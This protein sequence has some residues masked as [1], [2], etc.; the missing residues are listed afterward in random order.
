MSLP[1]R[2]HHEREQQ[3]AVK[4]LKQR[5]DFVARGISKSTENPAAKKQVSVAPDASDAAENARS[6]KGKVRPMSSK[7]RNKAGGKDGAE[8]HQAADDFGAVA[9]EEDMI[10]EDEAARLARKET[11][12]RQQTKD[13][14][15]DLPVDDDDDDEGDDD[16]EVEDDFEEEEAADD[17]EDDVAQPMNSNQNRNR[18]KK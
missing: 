16:D 1:L 4:R 18:A 12:A 8:A 6:G 13:I 17:I 14:G 7:P 3:E 5:Y 2:V 11:Y 10:M 9:E 15:F